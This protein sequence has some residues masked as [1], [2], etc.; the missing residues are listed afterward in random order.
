MAT[1]QLIS[2]FAGKTIGNWYVDEK[3]GEGGYGV[4]YRARHLTLDDR[5]AAIKLLK[6][7]ALHDPTQIER[8]RN[9]ARAAA[10]IKHPGI[11]RIDD[12]GEHA[13]TGAQYIIMEYLRG[14]DLQRRLAPHREGLP[15][16]E[17][18]DYVVGVADVLDAVH[19]QGIIHRDIK[20]ENVFLTLDGL[21]KLLD[22]GIAKLT[23][24]LVGSFRT[25]AGLVLGSP[26][27]FAPELADPKRNASIDHRSDVFSL[28]A[29]TY[30]LITHDRPWHFKDP[31]HYVAL[32][33]KADQHRP[34][35]LRVLR[36]EAP[37]GWGRTI[38]AG[39]SKNPDDRTDSAGE[40]A[41]ALAADFPR[42]EDIAARR[43][44]AIRA[45][46]GAAP[47]SRARTSPAAGS[48]AAVEPVDERPERRSRT[49]VLD[50]PPTGASASSAATPDAPTTA[51]TPT[52]RETPAAAS[53]PDDPSRIPTLTP[54]RVPTLVAAHLPIT[55]ALAPPALAP[56]EGPDRVP[57]IVAS[58]R[59]PTG[60]IPELLAEPGPVVLETG[61]TRTLAPAALDPARPA[62][63]VASGTV[64]TRARP[65]GDVDQGAVL[66]DPGLAA[67]GAP[68]RSAPIGTPRPIS[69]TE[70]GPTTLGGAAG[71]M[72]VAPSV[73]ARGRRGLVAA[74][75]GVAVVVVAAAVV[76]VMRPRGGDGATR[77]D[78]SVAARS[79]DAAVVAA[80]VPLDG[81]PA[82]PPPDAAPQLAAVA[83]DAGAEP[84]AA[85]VDAAPVE[86]HSRSTS[87]TN[88]AP[89]APGTLIITASPFAEIE[90]D[91]R[92]RGTTP[93]T[94]DLPPKRYRVTL[95][96][97]AGEVKV[98]RVEVASGREKKLS[99]RWTQP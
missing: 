14:M 8:F 22:L 54:E 29:V 75:V 51:I 57:T 60:S 25:S 2:D 43:L 98:F 9:E 79:P 26:G 40:F 45:A 81:A 4:V 65:A 47:V 62:P 6:P 17:V 94:L 15:L 70:S 66:L 96:G 46:G 5:I 82:L 78:E 84:L 99:H 49:P 64:A 80:A 58:P 21:I 72:R 77:P 71:A 85:P 92:H 89:R 19:A 27:Y 32:I 18:L 35:D 11:V 56:L 1:L 38:M 30:E 44:D 76:L 33:Q 28:A 67:P 61:P 12:I 42:G 3:I 97:P 50:A 53:R 95:T 48:P 63:I 16:H 74:I 52:L 73:Q 13:E 93:L 39:L 68:A 31:W 7:E 88:S 37:A 23:P 55:P 34:R 59:V 20:P 10:R 86:R 91:G 41:R 87:R 36:P 69:M 83:V 90:I 24:D